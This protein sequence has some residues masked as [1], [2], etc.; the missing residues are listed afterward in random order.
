MKLVRGSLDWF[1][2]SRL[3][4]YEQECLREE[5]LEMN[6]EFL[7]PP[8]FGHNIPIFIMVNWEE[9]T[10]NSLLLIELQIELLFEKLHQDLDFLGVSQ[11]SQIADPLLLL[12]LLRFLISV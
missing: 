5:V 10:D 4:G 8:I 11:R 12:L 1:F 6:L 9:V 2:Y 7:L 3:K